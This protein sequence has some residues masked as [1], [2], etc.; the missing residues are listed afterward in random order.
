L[1]YKLNSQPLQAIFTKLGRNE[2]SGTSF[3]QLMD[4]EIW[5]SM[6]KSRKKFALLIS[7]LLLGGACVIFSANRTAA[8]PQQPAGTGDLTAHWSQDPNLSKIGEGFSTTRVFYKML[9]AV[10]VIVFLAAAFVYLS[11]KVLPKIAALPNKRIRIIESVSLGH[12]KT[13]HLIEVSGQS[14]LVGSTAQTIT[15]L[16]ELNAEKTSSTKN[17]EERCS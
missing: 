1:I 9:L 2:Y 12:Q 13:V 16:G 10:L 7:V 5:Q 6:N 8:Q 3:A 17:L 15:K 11:K 4:V 14:F